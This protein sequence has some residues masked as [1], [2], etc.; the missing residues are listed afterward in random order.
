MALW[1]CRRFPAM[2]KS[3]G[4]R[5]VHLPARRS[6]PKA[7]WSFP[8]KNGSPA[9]LRKTLATGVTS[10]KGRRSLRRLHLV[11]AQ[12]FAEKA[13][14]ARR[15]SQAAAEFHGRF[16]DESPFRWP[17]AATCRAIW[18]TPSTFSLETASQGGPGTVM[19]AKDRGNAASASLSPAPQARRR[20]FS[21]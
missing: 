20:S 8:R 7:V 19:V 5:T 17:R 14:C 13:A 12:A 21:C 16:N 10:F 18:S 6:R 11:R 4:T 2:D 15:R 9:M 3:P 1:P